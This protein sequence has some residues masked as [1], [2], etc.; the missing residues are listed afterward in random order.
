[1]KL[2]V[3]RLRTAF[4][5]LMHQSLRVLTVF[6]ILTGAGVVARAATSVKLGAIRQITGPQ[7]LDLEGDIVYAINFSANDPARVVRGITFLPDRLGIPGA[8]LVGPQQVSPWQSKPEFGASA[9]ANALEEIL[10]DIRWANSGS[11][12]RLRATLAVTTGDEYKLQILISANGAENRRWDIRVNG[13]DAVDEITS[14][15]SSPGQTYSRSRATLYT[16]QF[17]STGSSAVIEMGTIFGA[18]EGGDRN[19][20]WQA[21][22]LEKVTVP[23]T[24][25]DLA[26]EP[27]KFFPSQTL[28]IGRLRALDRKFAATHTFSFVTG[29]GDADNAKFAIQAA[30][31]LPSPFNFSIAVPGTI[32][33]M[34][35]RGTDAADPARFIEKALTVQLVA[36]HAP[37]GISLDASSISAAALPGSLVARLQAADTDEFDGHVFELVRGAGDDD[38]ALFAVTG[39]VLTLATPLPVGATLARL[40][41]RATDHAGLRVEAAFQLPV[42]EPHVRLNEIMAGKVGGVPNESSAPQEWIELRNDLP[43]SVDL[44]GWYLTDDP[45]NPRQWKMPERRLGPNEFLLILADGTGASVPGSPILHANFSL[46]TDGE[47]VALVRPDGITI[48]S[49]WSFPNQFPGVAY[50][51]GVDGSLGY[52]SPSTPGEANGVIAGAGENPVSFSQPHGFHTKAFPLELKAELPGSTIRYTL[53]RT[54]P[55]PTTGTVYSGP[56][57]VTPNTSGT[58]RGVRIVRAIA[59]NPTAAYSPVATQTYLFVNGVSGPTVDGVVGQTQLRTSITGHAVYGPLMDDALLALPA[60]SVV[61]SGSVNTTERVASVELVDPQ[62]L[63]PGFQV[64]CGIEVTGTSSLGSPKPS[65]SAKFRFDY[66]QSRLRYPVFARGSMVPGQAATQFK[67]LRLRSHSHDTFYWLGTRE[68]PPVPYGNPPVTRAGD[69]QLAR[70]PWIDEMQILMGQPGKHGRQV[71]FFVNGA[72]QGIYHIHEHPDEDFMASYVRGSAEHFHFTGGATTGSE[73]GDGDSWRTAWAS[74]KASLGNYQQARRWVDVTNLCDYMILSFY[75]GND[76]DWSTQHNWGAAGP[77]FPDRGGWKF[78]QQDSD[79]TLQDVAADCTDQDVPDGIFTRLMTYPDFRVLFRDRVYKHCFGQGVLTPAKAGALYEA[80]MTEIATAIVADTARWQPSSS[81]AALPWDRD[82]EWTNEW[83]YL[84]NTFFPQRTTRL[85]DQLRKHSGW[86]PMAPPVLNSSG[87]SVPAGFEVTFT[88]ST[89]RAYFTTDGSDPRLPGGTVNPAARSAVG[90]G[91][92]TIDR[93]V[94]VKARVYTGTDWSALV[95]SYFFPEGTPSASAENIVPTEIHFHPMDQPDAEFLEIL[96]T[97]TRTVDLSDVVITNAVNFKFPRPALIGAGA[98]VVVVRNLAVFDTLYRDPASRFFQDGLRV[99]GPWSGSLSNEGETIEFL[100]A[101]GTPMFSCAYSTQGLWPSRADGRGS[102]LELETPGEVPLTGTEKSVWLRDARQWRPSSKFQGSPGTEGSVVRNSIV[103]NEL[104]VA[105]RAGEQDGV[106]LLNLSGETVAVDG[107]FLSDSDDDYLKYRIPE[108]T[109]I[110]PG[111]RFVLRASDFDN[112]ANPASLTPFGLN[113][114]GDNLFLVEAAP[115]GI[116]LRFVDTVTFGPTPRGVSIGRYPEG[117]GPFMRLLEATPG[118]L[119]AAPVPGYQAWA[120]MAFAGGTPPGLTGPD[121]DPDG[122]GVTNFAE[123]AFALSPNH[124]TRSPLEARGGSVQGGFA[125]TY[126]RRTAAS[127]L[128][129][130]IESSVDLKRWE[131]PVGGIEVLS[132]TAKPDGS[133][134]VE[135]RLLPVPGEGGS[136]RFVRLAVEMQ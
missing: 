63:E 99:F 24:P 10:Q 1:M 8:T 46:D 45:Q 88:V 72:Y 74:M 133:T 136:A 114:Q 47:W 33:S 3:C 96:N 35:V 122:D 101:E 6:A 107:W 66:G 80:R 51:Y 26:L 102:S 58:T 61:V 113:D 60:V 68:N 130:R 43:Q 7:D 75:A 94:V 70:N 98:R 129:Y 41:L 79:I 91:V 25:D 118:L 92:A 97:S 119:N 73:H 82:Q 32:Y 55:T 76:W 104:I 83:K 5:Q 50:G 48:A 34:R 23:P 95:E 30:N 2:C 112:P 37:A 65:M 11:G 134:Q 109:T 89:G 69:A 13:R 111:A 36:P 28:P 86:W 120:A 62:N 135:V 90:G 22:T 52:L 16:C 84:R 115:G 14:L 53:D 17:V 4:W 39:G 29:A 106:E 110:G 57:T 64:D 77:R 132:E 100:A 124:W 44:T 54:R 9:D 126:R 12:E 108:G 117:T 103:I 128:K 93:P 15:G 121:A 56:I 116:L 105:P 42:I 78:F 49:E 131:A 81:V 19:P 123:Y 40:R 38:N 71:H 125:F 127:G 59:V 31:L 87:G 20:I 85:I 18:N 67:E 21:L 27:S